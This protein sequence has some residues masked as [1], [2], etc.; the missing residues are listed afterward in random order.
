MLGCD[1]RNRCYGQKD[2]TVATSCVMVL[3]D[4]AQRNS[5]LELLEGSLL[6]L[7][8]DG[9]GNVVLRRRACCSCISCRVEYMQLLL[10]ASVSV[11]TVFGACSCQDARTC[12]A[13][14]NSPCFRVPTADYEHVCRS[15]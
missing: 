9:G 5:V 2:P 13:L 1:T 4:D 3:M 12:Q 7:N 14:A 8:L 15:S 6:A 10:V 11:V